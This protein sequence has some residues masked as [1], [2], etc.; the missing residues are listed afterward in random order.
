MV[1]EWHVVFD[2]GE[3]DVA[4]GGRK[5]RSVWFRADFFLEGI[6]REKRPTGEVG[7]WVVSGWVVGG[8]GV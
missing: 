7:S 2:G 5:C 1:V 8:I 4:W 6:K 3:V